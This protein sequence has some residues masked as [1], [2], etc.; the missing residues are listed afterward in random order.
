MLQHREEKTFE[1]KHLKTTLTYTSGSIHDKD[2]MHAVMYQAELSHNIEPIKY[3]SCIHYV[4]LTLVTWN[5]C[6]QTTWQPDE[7]T[8]PIN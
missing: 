7:I 4:L 6:S 2:I 8:R 3:I 5:R 1:F